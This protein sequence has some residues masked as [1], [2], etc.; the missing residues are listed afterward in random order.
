M[1][2]LDEIAE[3]AHADFEARNRVRDEALAQAR[4]LIRH[5]SRAIRAVHRDEKDT[6]LGKLAETA[7]LAKQLNTNLTAYPELYFAGY[8]QDALKEFAEAS[9]VFALV[10]GG[11]FPTAEGLSIPYNTYLKGLSEAATEMRRR[12]LDLMRE[13]SPA[14]AEPVLDLMEDIYALLVTMDY[15]DA[16]TG[17]LRRQTD[18]VRG[19]LERTRGD[20]TVSLRQ[21]HL[22][23]SLRKLEARLEGKE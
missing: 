13:N 8:T 5:A 12:C 11:D 1:D 17:G 7:A 9:I 15:P 22:E 19:V 14:A 20:L 2:I 23:E 10:Y 16:I 4:S 18:I 21:Q 6:A 3:R